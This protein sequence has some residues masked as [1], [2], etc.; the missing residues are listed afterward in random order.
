MEK[1]NLGNFAVGFLE[2][3]SRVIPPLAQHVAPEDLA[4]ATRRY[5]TNSHNTELGRRGER[6]GFGVVRACIGS[7]IIAKTAAAGGIVYYL[8]AG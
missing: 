8:I 5:E 3:I 7:G 4:Y 1:G 6:A 2:Y